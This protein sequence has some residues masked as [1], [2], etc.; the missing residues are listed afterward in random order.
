VH[1][2][3]RAAHAIGRLSSH[4]GASSREEH[5]FAVLFRIPPA[6]RLLAVRTRG[7]GGI[8]S[9]IYWE[10]E[11]CD[12]TGRLITRYESF[13]ETSAAGLGQTG[14]HKFDREG[15]LVQVRSPCRRMVLLQT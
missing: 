3:S 1:G 8:V 4:P 9:G 14:W 11:E 2:S 7:R 10:C 5:N 13:N 15:N 12:T 6:H